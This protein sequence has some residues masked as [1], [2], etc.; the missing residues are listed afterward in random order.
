M[1][2]CFAKGR[3]QGLWFK[4]KSVEDVVKMKEARGADA[5]FERGLLKAWKKPTTD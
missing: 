3:E 2:I 4:I 5:L 1:A